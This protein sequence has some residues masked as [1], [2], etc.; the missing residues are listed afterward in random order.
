MLNYVPI[1]IHTRNEVA[2]LYLGLTLYADV[3]N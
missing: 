3:H 2:I 1:L